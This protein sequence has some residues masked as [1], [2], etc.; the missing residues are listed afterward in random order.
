MS[1]YAKIN[2]ENIVE[3]IVVCEDNAITSFSGLYVKETDST[4]KADIDDTWDPLNKKFIGKKMFESW[5]LNSNFEWESP[6][7]P[8]PTDADYYWDE[9]AAIWVKQTPGVLRTPIEE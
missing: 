4:N 1:I 8:K 2:S 6:A 9:E 5:V 7:G 3:N